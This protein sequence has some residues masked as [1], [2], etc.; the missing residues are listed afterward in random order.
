MDHTITEN[1]LVACR[2]ENVE[3]TSFDGLRL[4]KFFL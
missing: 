2:R 3:G 4:Q 1:A